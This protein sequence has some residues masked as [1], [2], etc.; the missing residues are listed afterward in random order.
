MQHTSSLIAQGASAPVPF[1]DLPGELRNHIYRYSLVTVDS[2]AITDGGKVPL[3]MPPA[4][5]ATCRQIRN[6]AL[7]IYYIEN[8]FMAPIPTFQKQSG[9]IKPSSLG[10]RRRNIVILLLWRWLHA[11][12]IEA[13]KLVKKWNLVYYAES[14]ITTPGQRY[15][16]PL[17]G[18]SNCP[19]WYAKPL[20][21]RLEH[22]GLPIQNVRLV[23]N[24]DKDGFWKD[25]WKLCWLT[26]EDITRLK[27]TMAQYS[28]QS[29]E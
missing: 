17:A 13:A 8:S 19:W 3:W 16:L 21:R 15:S 1:L 27:D 24:K 10:Y 2:I 29:T 20:M 22:E 14:S 7:P 28:S 26:D 12:G 11:I 9:Y 23:S 18:T 5:L 4:V 6:E 25:S